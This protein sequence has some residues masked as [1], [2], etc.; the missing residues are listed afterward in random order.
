[1]EPSVR[2]FMEQLIDNFLKEKSLRARAVVYNEF[3]K[4]GFVS[5]IED[6]LFGALIE[7]KFSTLALV[8]ISRGSKMTT[9][10]MQ[11]LVDIVRNRSLDIKSKIKTASNF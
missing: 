8:N 7:S 1:M 11:E 9:E 4:I 5:S 10:E 2:G 3:K 6:A